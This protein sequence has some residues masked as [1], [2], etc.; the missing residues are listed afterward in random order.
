MGGLFGKKAPTPAPAPA[1]IA[2]VEE[3]KLETGVSNKQI[4]EKSLKDKLKIKKVKPTNTLNSGV[5]LGRIE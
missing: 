4:K 1:P 3:A 2:P 5:G